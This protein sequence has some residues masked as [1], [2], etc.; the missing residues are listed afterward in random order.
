MGELK[1]PPA[2]GP[3]PRSITPPK[4]VTCSVFMSDSPKG[5]YKARIAEFGPILASSNLDMVTS[6]KLYWTGFVAH[7]KSA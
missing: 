5:A 2:F 3:F 7:G 4:D 1:S 6:E